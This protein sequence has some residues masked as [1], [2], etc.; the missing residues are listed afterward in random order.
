M[1]VFTCVCTAVFVKVPNSASGVPG[2][3]F[4]A[5]RWERGDQLALETLVCIS[6]YASI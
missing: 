4:A 2:K 5:E 6:L 3:L 1:C